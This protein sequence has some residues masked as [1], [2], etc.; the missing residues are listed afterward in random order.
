G[1]RIINCAR[2]GIVDEDALA[3]MLRSRRL[4]AAG[5]DVFAREPLPKTSPLLGLSNVVLTPHIGSA[6]ITTRARMIDLA[7]ANLEAGLAFQ[8]L[9]RC[10]NPQV[11]ETPAYRRRLEARL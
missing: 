1:V 2:G 3:E 7:L 11:Y 6:S 5:L 8:P 9:P 4:A 10:A